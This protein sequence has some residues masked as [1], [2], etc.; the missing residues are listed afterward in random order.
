MDSE[1]SIYESLFFAL[2][3]VLGQ[4]E[5]VRFCQNRNVLLG[6]S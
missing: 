2:F 4:R 6:K 3:L 1:N 5:N